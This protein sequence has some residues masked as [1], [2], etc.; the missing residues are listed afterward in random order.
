[1]LMGMTALLADSDALSHSLGRMYRTVW[2]RSLDTRIR[3][4]TAA[5]PPDPVSGGSGILRLHQRRTTAQQ[6]RPAQQRRASPTLRAA[7]LRTCV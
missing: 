7:S 4:L 5:P 2:A 1:M 6:R 3:A